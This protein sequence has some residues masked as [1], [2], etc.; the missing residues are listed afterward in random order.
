MAKLDLELEIE[1]PER[2]YAVAE[3]ASK[4]GVERKDVLYA[5]RRGKLRGVKH[6]WNWMILEKDLPEKWPVIIRQ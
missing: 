6:G 2:M 1:K 3:V 4:F 5:L